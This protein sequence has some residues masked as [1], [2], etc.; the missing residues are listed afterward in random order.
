M[1]GLVTD[2]A[3]SNIFLSNASIA[4]T[5]A[6]LAKGSV[7]VVGASAVTVASMGGFGYF[8]GRAIVKAD[9]LFFEGKI[10]DGVGRVLEPAF[11]VAYKIQSVEWDSNVKATRLQIAPLN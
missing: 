5:T 6:M 8:V 11:K 9:G 3:V 10:I 4:A 7:L 2:I 1:Y